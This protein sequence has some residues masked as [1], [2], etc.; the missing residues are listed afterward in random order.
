MQTRLKLSHVAQLTRPPEE[1]WWREFKLLEA[2][3]Q[4]SSK[5]PA[6]VDADYLRVQKC[7][8]LKHGARQKHSQIVACQGEN[9]GLISRPAIVLMRLVQRKHREHLAGLCIKEGSSLL[10]HGSPNL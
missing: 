1:S 4:G 3:V 9:G 2:S 5:E 6:R 8:R 7:I 10:I